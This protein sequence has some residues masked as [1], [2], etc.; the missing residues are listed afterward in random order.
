[1]KR[2]LLFIVLSSLLVFCYPAQG[3]VEVGLSIE[4]AFGPGIDYRSAVGGFISINSSGWN[5][6]I[7][8]GNLHQAEYIGGYAEKSYSTNIWNDFGLRGAH[9]T[10]GAFLFGEERFAMINGA[11]GSIFWGA[12][13]VMVVYTATSFVR[14]SVYRSISQW[15][16]GVAVSLFLP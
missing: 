12:Y 11:S 6:G 10:G 2:I 5:W 8:G 1:M 3:E 16:I 9:R 15:Y 7:E 4:T 14:D 13:E